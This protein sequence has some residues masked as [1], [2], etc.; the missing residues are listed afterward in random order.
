MATLHVRNVPAELHASVR[1]LAARDR[2]SLNAQIVV[3]LEQAVQL[4]R[5]GDEAMAALERI[6]AVRLRDRGAGADQVVAWLRD[7]RDR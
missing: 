4:R 7:D 5:S 3:L 1:E 2:R 6:R